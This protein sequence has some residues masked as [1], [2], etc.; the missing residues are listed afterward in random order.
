MQ[1][2]PVSSTSEQKKSLFFDVWNS[3]NKKISRGIFSFIFLFVR[4][5]DGQSICPLNKLLLYERSF[6]TSMIIIRRFLV[7]RTNKR[8]WLGSKTSGIKNWGE[9]CGFGVKTSRSGVFDLNVMMIWHSLARSLARSHQL[10]NLITAKEGIFFKSADWRRKN[11]SSFVRSAVIG[12]PFCVFG[13]GK[14]LKV[15]EGGK[16]RQFSD[17]RITIV[18]RKWRVFEPSAINEEFFRKHKLQAKERK[19]FFPPV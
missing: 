4:R 5:T 16:G 15:I 6:F 17:R 1:S 12:S 3:Y 9:N 14:K 2:Q 19:R 11:A 7:G 18:V 8:I 13:G 10:T